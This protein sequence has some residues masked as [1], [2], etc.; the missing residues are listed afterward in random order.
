MRLIIIAAF[1]L[2]LGTMLHGQVTTGTVTGKVVDA[3]TG[4]AVPGA[5]IWIETDGVYVEPCAMWRVIIEL[6]D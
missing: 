2:G 4:A 6:M 1:F 5:K 3:I